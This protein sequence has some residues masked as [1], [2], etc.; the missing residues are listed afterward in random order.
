MNYS[1]VPLGKECYNH[2]L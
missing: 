2:F 1:L